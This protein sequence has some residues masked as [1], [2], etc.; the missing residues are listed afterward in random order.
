M[1]GRAASV[2]SPFY[3]ILLAF[4]QSNKLILLISLYY[5][6]VLI[7]LIFRLIPRSAHIVVEGG[8][9]A[10]QPW[11]PW[12]DLQCLLIRRM[13]QSQSKSS[14]CLT[15]HLQSLRN[16]DSTST[17]L[18]SKNNYLAFT[19]T[20]NLFFKKKISPWKKV[21]ISSNLCFF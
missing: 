19:S 9:G 12:T 15:L 17:I 6:V 18:I 3:S 10:E 14:P 8:G 5:S 7:V 11:A 21:V 4:M 16:S 2:L 13:T 20:K 1:V